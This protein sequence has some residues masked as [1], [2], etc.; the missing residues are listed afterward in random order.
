MLDQQDT[1]EDEYLLLGNEEAQW[2]SL[3][4]LMTGLM[5]IFMLIAVIL[6][7]KADNVSVSPVYGTN[8]NPN[9]DAAPLVQAGTGDSRSANSA[10]ANAAASAKRPASVGFRPANQKRTVVYSADGTSKLVDTQVRS[11]D[12]VARTADVLARPVTSTSNVVNNG[13]PASDS[14]TRTVDTTVRTAD[15]TN[16]VTDGSAVRTA[17]VSAR[18]VDATIRSSDATTRTTP[19]NAAANNAV[20]PVDPTANY[21]DQMTHPADNNNISNALIVTNPALAK[22]LQTAQN[23]KQVAVLYDQVRQELYQELNSQ[24]AKDLPKWNAEITKDLVIRF[25]DPDVLFKTGSDKIQ[26][27][28]QAIL[29]D[30]F[31]RYVKI[32][33]SEKYRS[34]IKEVRIE[35]HTSTVWK[36][37]NDAV[38][39]YFRNMELSQ[40]RTRS[41]LRFSLGL[42]AVQSQVDWLRKYVTA[43][44]LSSSRLIYN[45]DGTENQLRS[46]RVEFRIRT[47]AESG[48]ASIL[49]NKQA[50]PAQVQAH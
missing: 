5:M 32:I 34:V 15:I 26:P 41:I 16:R 20:H 44:G 29:N 40:S 36:G 14:N 1:L 24:F 45:A 35:G 42:P 19:S 49:D 25:N 7:M 10:A 9:V 11:T 4:D 30:F 18:P 2:I 43:N 22:E 28:Y 21:S 46:Q 33:T 17:D 31:P 47:D 23:I 39:A 50:A 6:L 8:T 27:K 13:I 48:I 12:T 38:E 37:T 3:S